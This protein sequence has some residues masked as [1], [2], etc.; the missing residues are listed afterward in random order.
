MSKLTPT[1]NTRGKKTQ[2]HNSPVQ[3]LHSCT[4]IHPP[5]CFK[6]YSATKHQTY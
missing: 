1:A 4:T 6:L 2:L 5:C 3:F